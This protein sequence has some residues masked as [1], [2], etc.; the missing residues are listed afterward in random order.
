MLVNI[1]HVNLVASIL[2]KL[3]SSLFIDLVRYL[4]RYFLGSTLTIRTKVLF[5]LI[6]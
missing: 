6:K 1:E 4:V 2:G 5:L 3:I